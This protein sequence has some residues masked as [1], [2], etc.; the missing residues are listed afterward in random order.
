[1]VRVLVVDDHGLVR[2]A[3][4]DLLNAHPAIEVVGQ[5]SDGLQAVQAYPLLR[6]DLV[7]MDLSMPVL[8]GVAATRR[9]RAIDERACVVLFT[10]AHLSRTIEEA[11]AAGAVACVHKDADSKDLVEA[12]LSAAGARG[13]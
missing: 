11:M 6:P 12:V 7:L 4:T 13:R 2:E 10:S 1:M 9:L 3:V 5:C 8:D